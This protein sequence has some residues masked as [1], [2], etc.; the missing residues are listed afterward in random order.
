MLLN[1]LLHVFVAREKANSMVMDFLCHRVIFE[2]KTV[3]Y[4]TV[5]VVMTEYAA[6][7]FLFMSSLVP[8]NLES[9]TDSRLQSSKSSPNT[10]SH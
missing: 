1:P 4:C 2:N 3:Q 10:V 6:L 7:F 5:L 8:P 9:T